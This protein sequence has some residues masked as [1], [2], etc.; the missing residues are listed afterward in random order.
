MADA[1]KELVAGRKIDA[2]A[3]EIAGVIA[4][5]F[6]LAWKVERELQSVYGGRV[7]FQQFGTEALD[8]R[9]KLFE[10][11]ERNGEITFNDAGVRHMFYYYFNMAHV[12]VESDLLEKPWWLL[13][14][15]K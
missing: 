3:G 2:D 11:A 13:D 15:P 8:A 1:E 7:I 10:E 9:R 6:I 12:V 14:S 5:E 4:R